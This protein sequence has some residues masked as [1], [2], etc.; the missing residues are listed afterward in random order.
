MDL[1]F[2]VQAMTLRHLLDNV[3]MP[4]GVYPVPADI[5]E[6]LARLKLETLGITIDDL[7]PDQRSY[8]GCET[9]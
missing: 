8:L 2:A 4:P 9:D 1:S 7:T 6:R 5:D 3:P